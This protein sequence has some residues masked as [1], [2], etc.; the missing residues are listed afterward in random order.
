MGL[1]R[2]ALRVLVALVAVSGVLSGAP[3]QMAVKEIR[4]RMVGLGPT[5]FDGTHV[6][7][8]TAHILGL[9]DTVIAPT[10]HPTPPHPS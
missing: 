10:H 6:A 2:R 3:T 4:P 5:V 1:R 8:F 9:L 7:A